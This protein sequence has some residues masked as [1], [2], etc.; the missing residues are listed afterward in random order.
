MIVNDSRQGSKTFCR[1][2]SNFF[3][4]NPDD[5]SLRAKLDIS[6]SWATNYLQRICNEVT[7]QLANVDVA[8]DTAEE[9][10]QQLYE[11]TSNSGY[12]S[13]W[14]SPSLVFD[15]DLSRPPS[16]EHLAQKTIQEIIH[17][18]LARS[19]VFMLIGLECHTKSRNQLIVHSK[20]LGIRTPGRGK[21]IKRN[22][23]IGYV[24]GRW[25]CISLY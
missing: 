25:L 22:T 17:K 18:V 16:P 9:F 2:K 15:D 7:D 3:P 12:Q 5:Q 8:Q 13:G 11:K 23:V 6:Q 20:S 24:L 19:W 21:K 10:L 14:K 4:E 1:R